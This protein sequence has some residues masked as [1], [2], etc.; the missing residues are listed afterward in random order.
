MQNTVHD[1][2]NPEWTLPHASLLPSH[3]CAQR[4]G[5]A[6]RSVSRCKQ[7]DECESDHA[8]RDGIQIR[9][10]LQAACRRHGAA[11]ASFYQPQ[12]VGTPA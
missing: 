11:A 7:V 10:L 1:A 8:A 4:S 6:G 5:C 9:R 3:F 12:N 2:A